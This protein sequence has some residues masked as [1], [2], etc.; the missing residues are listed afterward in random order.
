MLNMI[1]HIENIIFIVA[2]KLIA[3]ALY[4]YI[5]DSQ[6]MIPEDNRFVLNL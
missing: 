3:L 1:E 4:I 5:H 6:L 2:L